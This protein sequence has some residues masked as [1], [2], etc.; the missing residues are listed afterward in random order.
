[1]PAPAWMLVAIASGF[2]FGALFS[3]YTGP[4][5]EGFRLVGGLWIDS[6]RM[7]ILPLVFALVVTGVADLATRGDNAARRIGRRLPMV[8][9]GILLLAAILA[10]LI[11]PP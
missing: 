4:A 6:L 11:V 7:T 5:T 8:L 9:V 3:R 2:A 1:M 10:A